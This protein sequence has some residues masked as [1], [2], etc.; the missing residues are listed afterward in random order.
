MLP[1]GGHEEQGV[2][3]ELKS[4]PFPKPGNEKLKNQMQYGIE[5]KLNN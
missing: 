1:I 4:Q 5:F 3:S 2:I